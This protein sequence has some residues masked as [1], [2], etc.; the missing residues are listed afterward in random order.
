[1]I[2]NPQDQ[3]INSYFSKSK[4]ISILIYNLSYFIDLYIN[5]F[6]NRGEDVFIKMNDAC[7]GSIQSDFEG[8]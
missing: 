7:E 5:K 2:L 1:M 3:N 4:T 8:M 6:T